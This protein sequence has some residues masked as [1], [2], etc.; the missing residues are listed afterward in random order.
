MVPKSEIRNPKPEVKYGGSIII[1]VD[2]EDWFQVENLRGVYPLEGWD[3]C[4]IRFD[5]ATKVLLDIFDHYRVLSTF[6]VL[7]WVAERC[8]GLVCEIA[9]RGHEIASHGYSH[10]LL[11]GLP[12]K[13]LEEELR[14]S[15]HLLEDITGTEV[16]GF[17]APGFSITEELL[18]LLAGSGYVYDSSYNAIAFNK[19]C[20]RVNGW[21]TERNGLLEKSG[22]V[23]F[24]IRNLKIGPFVIPWGGGGYFRLLP[25]GLFARGVDRILS[26]DGS[27]VFYIHPW[28]LD[29]V[30]PR[31][32]GIGMLN[33][34]RHYLHLSDM[35]HRINYFLSAFK[36]CRFT[37]CSGYLQNTVQGSQ[38]EVQS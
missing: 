17:R 23:E 25:P 13:E 1:T 37:G 19:R 16:K 12:K 38:F 7:G 20:G 9:R 2:L 33:S 10:R 27:Y 36:D 32:K 11:F 30:Q 6:F 22:V 15:K 5:L 35:F 4:D 28:E 34:F 24:F 31:T 29:S 3:R 21:E 8:P 18:D 26:E 14:S